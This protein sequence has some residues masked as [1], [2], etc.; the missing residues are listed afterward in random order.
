MKKLNVSSRPR[1]VGERQPRTGVEDDV[2]LAAALAAAMVE[3][4]AFVQQRNGKEDSAD[5]ETNWR[6][7]ACWERL[8][9]QV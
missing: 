4:R 5:G 7:V 8:Q 2:L 9:G 3:Y 6:I 1:I